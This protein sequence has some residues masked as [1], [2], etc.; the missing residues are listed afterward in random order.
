MGLKQP[1]WATG[2][3]LANNT[4]VYTQPM[5]FGVNLTSVESR[6]AFKLDQGGT[7]RN[8]IVLLGTAPG[9]TATR[10]ITVR[11]NG[12]D[13]AVTVTFGAA[14]T[15]KSD[16]TNSVSVAAGDTL[17]VKCA[18]TNTPAAST[19]T[20]VMELETASTTTSQYAI[21]VSETAFDTAT[22][23]YSPL[24]SSG[25]WGTVLARA[26]GVVGVAGTITSVRYV[27][28]MAPTA[29]K[30]RTF[31]IE[32]NGVA[33]DGT[34]G[35]PN[36]VV[37]ISDSATGGTA[38]F[39]LSVAAG[40]LL[41]VKVVPAGGPSATRASGTHSFV[42]TTAGQIVL[43]AVPT[44]AP[45]SGA[46]SYGYPVGG[47]FTWS[48]T[49]APRELPGPATTLSLSGLYVTLEAAMGAGASVVYTLRNTTS[50]TAQTV[51]ISAG[52]TTG[53]PSGGAAV[54]VSRGDHG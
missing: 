25:T 21:G 40:D 32:K 19:L 14:D 31:T 22:T 38:T 34:A 43:A 29:G 11:K 47:S 5:G 39:S 15:S 45:T 53:G 23:Q 30:S 42:A 37:T 10:T 18:A 17:V 41:R 4:T 2:S 35:T 20:L 3:L 48:A 54:C 1:H 46:T 12:V 26:D 33:Q 28:D 44:A 49:E 7:V 6:V 16:T 13:Q 8:L 52:A 9:G 50:D 51:T 27:I 24:F 36:T